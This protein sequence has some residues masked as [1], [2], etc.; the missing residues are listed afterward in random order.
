MAKTRSSRWLPDDSG[1]YEDYLKAGAA[2]EIKMGQ[3]ANPVSEGHLPGTKIIGDVP[4]TSMIPEGS[5]AI[6]PAL[7]HD[8]IYSIEDLRQL[9]FP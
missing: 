8:I 7:H 1:V 9:V 4:R 6:S 2:I 5:D 3:G